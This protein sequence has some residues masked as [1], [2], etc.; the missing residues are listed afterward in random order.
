MVM[1]NSYHICTND[2]IGLMTSTSSATLST[3]AHALLNGA[4]LYPYDVQSS[5]VSELEEWLTRE[6]ISICYIPS[7]LFRN[8]AATLKVQTHFSDLRL[9]H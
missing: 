2:K 7:P 9:I 5:G 4:T 3:I 1:T 8:M 6:Q